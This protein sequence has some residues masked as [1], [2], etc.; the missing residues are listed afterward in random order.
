MKISEIKPGMRGLTVSG[1][2]VS[3]GN[4]K[5]VET[6]FGT[7]RVA[8]AVLQNGTGQIIL[9]LWRDQVNTVKRGCIVRVENAFVKAFRGQME[10]NVGRDGRIIVLGFGE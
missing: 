4:V 2:I 9:N 7:A 5:T 8:Q 1:R 6:K 10:L 3:I